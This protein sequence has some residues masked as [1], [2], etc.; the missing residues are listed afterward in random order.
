MPS[1]IRPVQ[2][3]HY[4]HFNEKTLRQV[5]EPHFKIRSIA[6]LNRNGWAIRTLL[7]NRFFILNERHLLK[8]L[9]RFYKR[10]YLH[11]DPSNGLRILAVV[12]D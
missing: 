5:L 6:F 1:D 4:Q 3:K 7:S 2:K 11:A 10:R 9:Y 12:T 8:W